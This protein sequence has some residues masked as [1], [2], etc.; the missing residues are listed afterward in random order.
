MRILATSGVSEVQYERILSWRKKAMT[1]KIIIIAS[2]LLLIIL[3]IGISI[4]ISRANR[5]AIAQLELNAL[6]LGSS[7]ES[8]SLAVRGGKLLLNDS[9]KE[10]DTVQHQVLLLD[11]PSV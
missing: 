3:T 2:I 10:L 7:L 11:D 5:L 1:K 4:G 8:H 6:G 9:L